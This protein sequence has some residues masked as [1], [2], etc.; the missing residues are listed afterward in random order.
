VTP[1]DL[2]RRFRDALPAAEYCS[3]RFVRERHEAL[4][5]RRDVLEPVSM[6]D[7]AGAM[8]TVADGGGVGYA[9][10][11]DLSA[12]GLRRAAARAHAWARATAGHL[13]SGV[14]PAPR[15]PLRGEYEHRPRRPWA[16]VPLR[17]KVDLLRAEC[18]RLRT[19]ARIVDWS[20][21]LWHVEAETLLL[22]ADG[23]R[24]WQRFT[25]L[26]P[27][28]SATA[29]RGTETQTRTLGGLA[30]GRQGGLE[31]L[32]DVGFF[33]AAPR[34]A[35]EALELLAVSDCPSGRMDLLLAPDQMI[36]QV[37]ESIGHPLELD[38]ILGDERNYAGT[39]FVTPAMVGSYRYGSDLLDVTFDPTRPEQFGSYGFDDEG[40]RAERAYV[41]KD[42][43]LLRPLGGAVSQRRAGLPGVASARATSWNRSPID[44]MANLNLEPR[45]AAF[46]DMVAAVA[47][48]VYMETNT[49][50]SIDDARNKFQ[51][52]CERG[53]LIED[54]RLTRVV[55]KPNY[56]GVSATF[57]RSLAM[58]GD[59]STVA[60]LG[61]P[62]C[63]KG[64]P[65]QTM[66]VGHA[67]PACLF[68]DV[69]V[70]G[71]DGPGSRLAG[72]GR[73]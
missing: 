50:W 36:L 59:A 33:A 27:A 43:I 61:T 35:A 5:V 67:A 26:L 15:G 44:R 45:D 71:G 6:S 10:T 49:S 13:V 1:D 28:M 34:L 9:A 47:R 65:N 38:R 40:E 14:S 68:R 3:L 63:G 2:E 7:D 72:G 62:F 32:D 23:A 16:S 70:F 48:G 24:V 29:N 12:A 21:G 4:S 19:D 22:S 69:E 66:R 18:V 25:Y 52:G 58:V 31:A 56:R 64:E 8:V 73:H 42:G 41:I 53:R 17:E 20:A 55:R 51:F 11:C 46:G 37:H 39:S 30:Y 57:W 54:G 60:V